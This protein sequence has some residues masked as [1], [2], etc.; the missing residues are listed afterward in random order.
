MNDGWVKLSEE[1]VREDGYYWYR[2]RPSASPEIVNSAKILGKDVSER[3]LDFYGFGETE[4]YS[5]QN[6]MSKFPEA[7]VSKPIKPP[8]G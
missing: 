6:L 4:T 3:E 5:V 2:D 8:Q 1:S 7:Q